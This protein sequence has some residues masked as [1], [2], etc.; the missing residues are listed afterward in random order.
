MNLLFRVLFAAHCRSTHHKLALDAL[1]HLEGTDVDRRRSLFL[2]HHSEFLQ[3]AKDPDDR[4]KDFC[5]HV[6]HVEQGYWGGAQKTARLWYGRTVEAL[7]RSSWAE[8]AYAAGVLSHYY[9]DPV[10]PFHTGQ[11]E[12]ENNIHRAAE[13]S[14]T[15]SYDRLR[16]I[17]ESRTDRP[18]VTVPAGTN[19]LEEMV[20]AGADYSHRYY[21]PLINE[22]DIHQGVKNPP[23]GLNDRSREFLAD[24]LGYAATGIARILDRAFDESGATPPGFSVT[25]EGILATVTVPIKWVGNQ[26]A[27]AQER[28]VV[29]A[30]YT[31]LQKTGR[32]EK[33]L[34]EDD[35]TV[36]TQ[37][38]KAFPAG[39]AKTIIAPRPKVVSDLT[40]IAK[41]KSTVSPAPSPIAGPAA[42]PRPATA[43][44][45]P[46]QPA[47]STGKSAGSIGR[48]YLELTSPVEDAPSIGA[49]TAERLAEI[50]IR[51]VADLLRADPNRAAA[52]LKTRHISSEVIRDWQDQAKL[53]CAVPQLR[54]HDAQILV[55]CGIR[56]AS[57]LAG[58]DAKS[59][60]KATTEFA[61]TTE[62]KRVL[63][64]SEQPDAA[65]VADWIRWAGQARTVRAA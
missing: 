16:Q 18:T 56:D 28:R 36:R 8:A 61:A 37:F 17:F 34:P 19:W 21:Q 45:P 59:L 20:A 52:Q 40:P 26:L 51:T 31:E 11:T 32:V 27:D 14:V 5:N 33:T 25:L 55:A 48:F 44:K 43:P 42:A 15:K 3:G 65:E 7:R 62:G 57:K 50:N 4:F 47:V 22:Y 58:A 24:L 63:R 30:M 38:E 39:T 60:L 54:G 53:V 13:W 9:T 46:P 49:K 6:L 23:A 10:M 64:S 41:T 12:A 29:E 2:K 1:K 35:R